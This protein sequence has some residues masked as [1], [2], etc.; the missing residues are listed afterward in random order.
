MH[1]NLSTSH[2]RCC[3][4]SKKTPLPPLPAA[5]LLAETL[6]RNALLQ[7]SQN[8]RALSKHTC[9]HVAKRKNAPYAPY[10]TAFFFVERR[11][12]ASRTA[13]VRAYG[14]HRVGWVMRA[15]WEFGAW[16]LSMPEVNEIHKSF[17]TTR[18]LAFI[19]LSTTF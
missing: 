14:R 11:K 10:A 1:F 9:V 5:T 2:Y 18:L 3:T 7:H 4:A 8:G 6:C 13:A 12:L 17:R 16:G 15:V 19:L